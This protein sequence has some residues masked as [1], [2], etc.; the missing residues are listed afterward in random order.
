MRISKPIGNKV[1]GKFK[2]S[3]NLLRLFA[4]DV[5]RGQK[6]EFNRILGREMTKLVLDGKTS[7]GKKPILAKYI[8]KRLKIINP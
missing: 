8:Q 7:K 3:E 4:K 1:K 5:R 6:D 2:R